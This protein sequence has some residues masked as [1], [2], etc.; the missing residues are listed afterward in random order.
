MYLN[1]VFVFR[2]KNGILDELG[3]SQGLSCYMH[4]ALKT[5]TGKTNLSKPITI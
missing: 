2:I 5:V 1:M 4:I 3:N